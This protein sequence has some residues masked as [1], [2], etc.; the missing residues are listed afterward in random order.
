M[1]EQQQPEQPE[2]PPSDPVEVAR[3]ERFVE[4]MRERDAELVDGMAPMVMSM[5]VAGGWQPGKPI[6]SGDL[7]ELLEN[8]CLAWE[9]SYE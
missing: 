9:E 3:L 1:D 2:T 7:V 8:V 5:L 6:P 4:A